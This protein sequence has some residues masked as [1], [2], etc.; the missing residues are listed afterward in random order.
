MYKS[1]ENEILVGVENEKMLYMGKVEEDEIHNNY[2]M[3]HNKNTGKIMLL[4]VDKATASPVVY[5]KENIL[6]SPV[7]SNRL[8]SVADLHK[9]FGS[10]ATKRLTEQRER[11]TMNIDA[12]K[13]QLEKT[14]SGKIIVSS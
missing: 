9:Q 7:A 14:V 12:V 13:D 10:K 2:L 8:S 3:V 6:S 1:T 5:K 11:L 4:Q